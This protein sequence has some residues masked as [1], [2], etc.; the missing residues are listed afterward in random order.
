[1]KVAAG[2]RVPLFPYL[3]PPLNQTARR[4]VGQKQTTISNGKSHSRHKQLGADPTGLLA[5]IR[6][7]E[8]RVPKGL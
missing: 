1:M 7:V 8:G 6:L 2:N 5:V 3:D 4:V